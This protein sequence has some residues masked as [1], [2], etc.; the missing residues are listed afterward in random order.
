MGKFFIVLGFLSIACMGYGCG[1]APVT[2]TTGVVEIQTDSL[3]DPPEKLLAEAVST[4]KIHLSWK[5]SAVNAVSFRIER[6]QGA[7]FR[8]LATVD[9][10]KLNYTDTDLAPRTI[11]YY[12]VRAVNTA[13]NSACSNVAD[14]KTPALKSVEPELAAIEADAISKVSKIDD[15]QSLKDL[16]IEREIKETQDTQQ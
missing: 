9:V 2:A 11:Y 15:T 13:G 10:S 5:S 8:E 14:A 6:L 3:P 16:E 4:S 1:A 7:E 12:R